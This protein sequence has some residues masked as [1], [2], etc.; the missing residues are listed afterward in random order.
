MFIEMENLSKNKKLI[1]IVKTF[2]TSS[3]PP[4]RLPIDPRTKIPVGSNAK[5]MLVIIWGF[6][7]LIFYAIFCFAM[8][9]W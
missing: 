8:K 2:E 5:Y 4:T 7:P 6:I 1:K 9:F 3:V